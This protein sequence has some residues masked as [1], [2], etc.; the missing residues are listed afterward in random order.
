M[1]QG[2]DGQLKIR[3]KRGKTFNVFQFVTQ[4]AKVN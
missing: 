4:K 1:F 3:E 2:R